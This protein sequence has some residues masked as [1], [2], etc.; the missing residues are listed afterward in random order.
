MAIHCTTTVDGS[1][2]RVRVVGF[3]ESLAEVENYGL[4]VIEAC[5]QGGVTRILCDE[6]DLEYRLGTF[7]T[8]KAAEALAMHAPRVGR[9]AIIPN[10]KHLADARFW[11]D[12]VVNRGLSVKVFQDEA[13]ALAW[14]ND[15]DGSARS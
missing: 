15:P 3:D 4:S 7:D 14:L 13:A 5:A 9:A 12:V 10:P 1:I 8:Y 11:E 2:L 6:R